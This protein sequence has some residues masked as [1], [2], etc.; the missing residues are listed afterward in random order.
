MCGAPADN[1]TNGAEDPIED[2]SNHDHTDDADDILTGDSTDIINLY[3]T[4]RCYA[5]LDYIIL[6]YITLCCA[7]HYEY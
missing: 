4:V 3:C 7:L 1:P 5:R 6:Y 2:A